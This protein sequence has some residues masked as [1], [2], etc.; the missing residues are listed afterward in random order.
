MRK[1][2]FLKNCS[3]EESNALSTQHHVYICTAAGWFWY[4]ADSWRDHGR[5]LG[6]GIAE[7]KVCICKHDWFDADG[8]LSFWDQY[9]IICWAERS[10]VE[11]H[12]IGEQEF[13][14]QMGWA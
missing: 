8:W 6:R 13:A 5:S 12:G 10:E 7:V 1:R 11:D 3:E 9:C 2:D 14:E 4:W